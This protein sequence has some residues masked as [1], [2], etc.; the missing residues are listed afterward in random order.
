MEWVGAKEWT[1][2]RCF[3]NEV[4]SGGETSLEEKDMQP[5]FKFKH[6]TCVY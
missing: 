2:R 6:K 3:E 4:I 1:V 5:V